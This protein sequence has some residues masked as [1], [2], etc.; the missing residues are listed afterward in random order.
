[1]SLIAAITVSTAF[2]AWW[3]TVLSVNSTL[4]PALRNVV[5]K[6]TIKNLRF[7]NCVCTILGE[8]NPPKNTEIVGN[9]AH[10]SGVYTNTR[11]QPF[12]EVFKMLIFEKFYYL[13]SGY[14]ITKLLFSLISITLVYLTNCGSSFLYCCYILYSCFILLHTSKFKGCDR[15][16][17]L[18][19]TMDQLCN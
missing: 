5:K 3:I 15:K 12:S 10:F 19:Y 14:V 1:M 16:N 11:N 8:N 13:K 7:L 17:V 9:G 18:E 4:Y 6:S 2:L